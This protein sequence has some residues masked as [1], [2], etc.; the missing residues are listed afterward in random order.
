MAYDAGSYGQS[1]YLYLLVLG[2]GR[3]IGYSDEFEVAT[4]DIAPACSPDEYHSAVWFGWPTDATPDWR[5]ASLDE[6]RSRYLEQFLVGW[7]RDIEVKAPVQKM[8]EIDA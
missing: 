7:K 3:L 1:D 4:Q 8:D 5:P 6:L 2:D